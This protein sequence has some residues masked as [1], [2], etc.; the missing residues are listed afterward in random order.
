MRDNRNEMYKN[1]M[2]VAKRVAI[3]IL[4][5]I[6]LCV[7]FGYFTR[8]VITTSGWQCVCFIAI[9]GIAVLIVEII[10]RAKEKNKD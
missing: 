6:P 8:N 9:M 7:L 10:A 4:S 3:T 2:K 1:F 5:C